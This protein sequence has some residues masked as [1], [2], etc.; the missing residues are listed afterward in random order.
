MG[1]LNLIKREGGDCCVV[2][3]SFL[4]RMKEITVRDVCELLKQMNSR[5]SCWTRIFLKNI[6]VCH[7]SE[8]KLAQFLYQKARDVC[9]W[10]WGFEKKVLW[11]KCLFKHKSHTIE[12]GIVFFRF[13]LDS[14]FFKKERYLVCYL[15]KREKGRGEY[16]KAK[17]IISLVKNSTG[18]KY[19]LWWFRKRKKMR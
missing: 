17:K 12:A 4:V 19:A 10:G 7:S 6:Y 16:S 13:E 15:L 8:T 1:D 5:V 14:C 2:D 3:F 11:L 18:K 9:V